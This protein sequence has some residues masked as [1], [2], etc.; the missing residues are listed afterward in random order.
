MREY[1]VI[2]KVDRR[3]NIWFYPQRWIGVEFIGFWWGWAS[4][5]YSRPDEDFRC[6]TIE[7]AC[8]YIEHEKSIE[9]K[10]KE[11]AG[12]HNRVHKCDCKNK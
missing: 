11:N 7:D 8:A 6:S 5:E 3:G 4:G 10:R 12:H 1:R 2:S 9:L